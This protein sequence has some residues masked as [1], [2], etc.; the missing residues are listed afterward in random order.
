[1]AT[2]TRYGR[3]RRTGVA[4]G[5]AFWRFDPS[6]VTPGTG[7]AQ[8]AT[9]MGYQPTAAAPAPMTATPYNSMQG[10]IA[11]GATPLGT[12]PDGMKSYVNLGGQVYA[13][14][15]RT[16]ATLNGGA[17]I[18]TPGPNGQI[19]PAAGP[20]GTATAPTSRV[21]ETVTG[22]T[23]AGTT[24]SGT[25]TNVD[26]NGNLIVRWEDGTVTTHDSTGKVIA[27]APP[28]GG[29]HSGSPSGVDPAAEAARI[30]AE[31]AAAD[32]AAAS[33]APAAATGAPMA[34]PVSGSEGM[35]IPPTSTAAAPAPANYFPASATELP[36]IPPEVAAPTAPPPTPAAIDTLHGPGG[37][38]DPFAADA[39]APPTVGPTAPLFADSAGH[40][41]SLAELMASFVVPPSPPPTYAA[42]TGAP[43]LDSGAIEPAPQPGLSDYVPTSYWGASTPPEAIAGPVL[44]A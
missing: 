26:P 32:A 13:F 22:R 3:T 30:A 31:K 28:V 36:Y 24:L 39:I 37:A 17:A 7:G 34:T 5:G 6:S 1:M 43:Y 9:S 42:P 40:M 20:A 41:M 44:T 15:A 23:A 11:M 29:Q 2:R 33:A 38:R 12:S 14:D 16:G 10:L 21:G 27:T 25:I 8:A 35:Y 4:F 18:G 19:I